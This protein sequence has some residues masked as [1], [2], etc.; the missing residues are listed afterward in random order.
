LQAKT[1]APEQRPVKEYSPD[2]KKKMGFGKAAKKEV[3]GRR[4]GKKAGK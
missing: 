4:Q 2:E 1:P 3:H